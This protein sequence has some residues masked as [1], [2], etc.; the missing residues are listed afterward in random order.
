MGAKFSTA[1][2]LRWRRTRLERGAKLKTEVMLLSGLR[3]IQ[4][5]VNRLRVGRFHIPAFIERHSSEGCEIDLLAA[6]GIRIDD[7]GM[8][9]TV[10][11]DAGGWQRVALCSAKALYQY[12]LCADKNPQ[13]VASR[14]SA[15]R[16]L[17]RFDPRIA[18]GNL[19]EIDTH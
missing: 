16:D 3:I 15:S 18:R 4:I 1:L 8:R 7:Q 5:K 6:E 19:D 13:L 9:A 14:V 11:P 2:P 17:R 10:Y 12:P